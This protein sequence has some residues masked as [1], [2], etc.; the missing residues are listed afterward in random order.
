MLR[1]EVMKD[2]QNGCLNAQTLCK[3]PIAG[4]NFLVPSES[5]VVCLFPV[6]D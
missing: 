2:F 4:N 1:S 3:L 5:M 6:I